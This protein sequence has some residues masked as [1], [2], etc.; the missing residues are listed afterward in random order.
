MTT[1][2]RP[3]WPGVLASLLV[4]VGCALGP[5]GPRGIALTSV[6]KEREIGS[7]EARKVAQSIGLVDDPVLTAYVR[8]IGERLVAQGERSAFTY[9]FHIVDMAEPNAFALPGG[10]VYVSR[11]LLALVNSEDELACVLG[12]EIGHVAARHAGRRLTLAAPLAIVTGLGATATGLVSPMLGRVV[13]GV[14][15]LTSGLVLAPYSREQERE[16]DRMGIA[17]AARAGW[18]PS[19]MARALHTLEREEALH[20][21]NPN[22]FS[23]FAS[24]PRMP[25][26]VAATAKQAG[27]LTPASAPPIAPDRTAFLARLDGLL[28]GADPAQ[29]VFT[30]DRF[31]HPEFD[32]ALDLP[33]RWQKHNTADAVAA[34]APDGGAVLI[35]ELAGQGT[36]PMEAARAAAKELSFDVKDAQAFSIGPLRAV[37]A[38]TRARP[39]DGTVALDLTWIAHG[40][41]IF[42][43]TGVSAPARFAAYRPAFGR[44]ARSFRPLAAAE[45]VDI[46][47]ARLRIQQARAGD[48]VA[49]VAAR[50]SSAWTADET[51]MANGLAV[52]APL[53]PQQP[54]KVAARE[55]Y[56][57]RA[58]A[59]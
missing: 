7:E 36:D 28:V 22:R 4:L 5:G 58:T 48:T 1:V 41:K 42:Q 39:R 18:D 35:V 10:Y 15:G 27:T 31:L 52:D 24:H 55:P 12:H 6:A 13:A 47:D 33:A 20:G 16:A 37:N 51:A 54:I 53:E 50:V 25:D 11:G 40:G 49:A 2:R 59:R 9:E 23:F 43:L 46:T 30:D 44:T 14:G 56:A 57:P 8:A 34:L 17:L 21:G 26:R 19:A 45:R 3:V 29:G 38:A 32:C